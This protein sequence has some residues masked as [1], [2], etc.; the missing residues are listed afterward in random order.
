[1]LLD[2]YDPVF[3]LPADGTAK[4]AWNKECCTPPRRK[5]RKRSRVGICTSKK[6]ATV[7]I[8]SDKDK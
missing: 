5:A 7:V 1:L 8:T 6:M 2:G 3:D 4:G